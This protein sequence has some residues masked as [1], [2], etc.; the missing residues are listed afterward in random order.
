ME[1]IKRTNKSVVGKGLQA[2]VNAY[3]QVIV[4]LFGNPQKAAGDKVEVEWILDTPFGV[5]TIY[6]WKDGIGYLGKDTGIPVDRITDWHIG[7][8]DEKVV[9][10]VLGKLGLE[11][12]PKLKSGDIVVFIGRRWFDKVNGNTYHSVEVWVNA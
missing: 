1:K 6:N 5:A 2:T 8:K 4:N 3:Y 7:G 9:A 12:K 10:W 11:D